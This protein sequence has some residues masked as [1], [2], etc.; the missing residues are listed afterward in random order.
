MSEWASRQGRAGGLGLQR[1]RHCAVPGM[2]KRPS[3]LAIRV[4]V[5]VCGFASQAWAVMEARMG[6]ATA[7]RYLFKKAL[8]ANPRSRWVPRMA[9]G[10]GGRKGWAGMGMLGR[11]PEA[12]A[13]CRWRQQGR[14]WKVTLAVAAAEGPSVVIHKHRGARREGE[15]EGKL[16]TSGCGR[17]PAS[18][19]LTVVQ[20]ATAPPPNALQPQH[21]RIWGQ[22]AGVPADA[23]QRAGRQATHCPSQPPPACARFRRASRP[24]SRPAQKAPHGYV[25]AR[26]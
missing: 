11:A 5:H 4:R 19:G 8:T 21:C 24:S 1:Q 13:R 6:D 16:W 10:R 25:R 26:A 17:V 23:P 2:R 20:I 15:A 18:G 14:L 3:A 22:V 9:E 12:G 7:V